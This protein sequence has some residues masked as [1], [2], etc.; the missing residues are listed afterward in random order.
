MIDQNAN[1]LIYTEKYD[2]QVDGNAHFDG[3][4]SLFSI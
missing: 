3:W 4:I 1:V 2:F